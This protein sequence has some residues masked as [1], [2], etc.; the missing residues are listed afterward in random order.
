[1]W[2]GFAVCGPVA[3]TQGIFP[4]LRAPTALIGVAEKG[5][6][7]LELSTTTLPGHSSMPPPDTAIGM[8]SMALV[9]LEKHPMPAELEGVVLQMFETLASEMQGIERLLL[10]NL[11][12]FNPLVKNKLEKGISTNAIGW[13]CRRNSLTVRA[14]WC[15]FQTNTALDNKLKQVALFI[16]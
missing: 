12:L 1:M 14:I 9:Q 10:S 2:A 6:L 13:P 15:V 16:I 4:G 5:I 11:W 8:L 3:I 7:T